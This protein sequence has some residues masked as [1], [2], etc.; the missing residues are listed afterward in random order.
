MGLESTSMHC[1]LRNISTLAVFNI[2]LL[3]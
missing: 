1:T 2:Y 3:I